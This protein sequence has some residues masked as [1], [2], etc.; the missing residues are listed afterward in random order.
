MLIRRRTPTIPYGESHRFAPCTDARQSSPLGKLRVPV[1]SA[2]LEGKGDKPPFH[3]TRFFTRMLS[4]T[5]LPRIWGIHHN[6][7]RR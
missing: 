6:K 2:I 1:G 3:P 5:L 7:N 4:V